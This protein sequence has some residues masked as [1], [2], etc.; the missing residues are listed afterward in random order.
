MTGCQFDSLT[1]AINSGILRARKRIPFHDGVSEKALG[2]LVNLASF[3]GPGFSG[4][5]ADGSA[6]RLGRGGR[7]FKS[8]RPDLG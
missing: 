3:Y 1:E 7:R 6:P 5:G 8:G 2:R 4:R